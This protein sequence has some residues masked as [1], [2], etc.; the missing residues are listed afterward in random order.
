LEEFYTI[1]VD[2]SIQLNQVNAN[3]LSSRW[4]EG[5]KGASPNASANKKTIKSIPI[6]E[7]C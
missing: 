1:Q 5:V 4:V 6:H 7:P 2:R 3:N